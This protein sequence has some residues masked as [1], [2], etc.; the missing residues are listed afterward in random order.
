[1]VTLAELL[2]GLL[3]ASAT[4]LFAAG[5]LWGLLP[6]VLALVGVLMLSRTD[7]QIAQALRNAA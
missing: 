6:A 1:L 4:G 5:I 7:A 2:L 3:I